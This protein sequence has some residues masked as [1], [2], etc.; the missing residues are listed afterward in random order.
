[1]LDN[2]I[3]RR[4][5]RAAVAVLLSDLNSTCTRNRN[6]TRTLM[7]WTVRVRSLTPEEFTLRYRVPLRAFNM[8]CAKIQTASQFYATDISVELKLSMLLRWLAGGSYLDIADMH[9]VHTDTFYKAVWLMLDC[10]NEVMGLP[11]LPIL[12]SGDLSALEST[13]AAYDERTS[14]VMSGCI[15]AL[16]GCAIKIHKP[17]GVHASQ[18]WCRKGFY[19]VNLQAVCDSARRVTWMAVTAVGSTHDS[20]AFAMTELAGIMNDPSH[21]LASTCYWIAGD[22]AY[23]GN[24]NVSNNLLTP[25]G[26]AGLGVRED[27]FNYYQSALRISIEGTFGEIASRWGILSRPL[28]CNLPHITSI[29]KGVCV[30]HNICKD[31]RVAIPHRMDVTSDN[32]A[33]RDIDQRRPLPDW[34]VAQRHMDRADVPRRARRVVQPLR[35]QLAT[36]LREHDMRRPSTSQFTYI[37]RGA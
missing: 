31:Y 25:Y 27:S 22:D 28:R 19:S 12:R 23:K 7:D 14:G 36:A 35:E 10:I 16:D 26:G 37:G 21:P 8:I 15:G 24:A 6:R 4:R 3:R 1:M 5:R 11:L 18:Y 9:G 34:R 33:Q 2:L 17:R 29:L 20:T 30:L 32:E 13:A